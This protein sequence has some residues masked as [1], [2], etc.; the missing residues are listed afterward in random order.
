M[1]SAKTPEWKIPLPEKEGGEYV[2]KPIV[3]RGRIIPWGY[4]QDEDDPDIL[5]PIPELLEY[6]EMAKVHLKKYSYREVAD[7][8]SDRT[9]VSI[10]YVGL[11][12][13]VKS[14]QRRKNKAAN[15]RYLAR[16]YKEALEKAER[17][18][19]NNTGYRVKA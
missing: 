1:P 13:R 2:W 12:N 15:L 9:G 10:S 14:E 16:K 3:R 4:K 6:L 5:I 7:W 19:R 17:I 11:Y 18:E 8:L